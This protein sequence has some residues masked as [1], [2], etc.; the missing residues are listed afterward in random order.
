VHAECVKVLLDHGKLPNPFLIPRIPGPQFQ[1]FRFVSQTPKK[2]RKPER[3]PPRRSL[4][5]T[6]TPLADR[7]SF[8]FHNLCENWANKSEHLGR[9]TPLSSLRF[10]FFVC[11]CHYLSVAVEARFLC[12][13]LAP[14]HHVQ[15]FEVVVLSFKTRHQ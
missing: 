15:T 13:V 7:S 3:S 12:I 6:R 1:R 10:T 11:G 8:A 4:V 5:T 2:K 9:S 14:Y